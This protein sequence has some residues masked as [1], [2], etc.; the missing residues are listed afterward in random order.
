MFKGCIEL[1]VAQCLIVVIVVSSFFEVRVGQKVG[2]SGLGSVS[3]TLRT[4][5]QIHG[6]T[7]LPYHQSFREPDVK[8]LANDLFQS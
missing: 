1:Y 8:E 6:V 3:G 5:G 7:G 2:S 4:H